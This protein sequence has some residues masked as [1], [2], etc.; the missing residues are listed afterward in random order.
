[1]PR[2][3]YEDEGKE[4]YSVVAGKINNGIILSNL[5]F[6]LGTSAIFPYFV[7]V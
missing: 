1:M 4:E 3:N 5:S 7:G 2:S 6:F